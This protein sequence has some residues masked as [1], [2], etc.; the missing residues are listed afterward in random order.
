MTG[1]RESKDLGCGQ[2]YDHLWLIPYPHPI[3]GAEK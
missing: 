2:Y 3:G 1:D